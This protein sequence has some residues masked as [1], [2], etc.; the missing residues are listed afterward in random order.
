LAN[1][2]IA[3]KLSVKTTVSDHFRKDAVMA[4]GT[5]IKNTLK[6]VEHAAYLQDEINDG[7]A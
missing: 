7:S 3:K 6:Y 1:G 2:I 5:K 4:S